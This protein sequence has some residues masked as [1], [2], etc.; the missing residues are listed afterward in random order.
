MFAPQLSNYLDEEL[1]DSA[2]ASVPWV[3]V[4]FSA[5]AVAFCLLTPVVL[6]QPEMEK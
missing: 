4:A 5:S 6:V 2:V 1:D 3:S